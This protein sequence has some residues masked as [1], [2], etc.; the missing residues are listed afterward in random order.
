MSAVGALGRRTIFIPKDNDRKLWH[1]CELS[2]SPERGRLHTKD[3]QAESF[4][5]RRAGRWMLGF[6]A[7]SKGG[8]RRDNLSGTDPFAQTT[9]RKGLLA[10]RGVGPECE[11]ESV[12][13]HGRRVTKMGPEVKDGRRRLGLRNPNN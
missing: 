8:P 5:L 10:L 6:K 9:D 2:P 7:R 11:A 3:E 13:F 12:R 1:S 4:G